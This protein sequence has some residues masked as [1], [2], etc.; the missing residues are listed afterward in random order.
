MNLS[1]D[2]H[3]LYLDSTDDE[4]DVLALNLPIS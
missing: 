4:P 3:H 1:C 2:I